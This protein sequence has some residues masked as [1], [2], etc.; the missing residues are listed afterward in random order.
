MRFTLTA[1]VKSNG[2]EIEFRGLFSV[3]EVLVSRT[4]AQKYQVFAFWP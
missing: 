4:L 3:R 1:V 2:R